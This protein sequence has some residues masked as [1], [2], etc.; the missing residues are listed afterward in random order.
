VAAKITSFRLRGVSLFMV[1]MLIE[2]EKEVKSVYN[3]DGLSA[4]R[5]KN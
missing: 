2:R 3:I 5:E 4:A 1:G